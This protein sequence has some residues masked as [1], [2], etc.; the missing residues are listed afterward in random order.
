MKIRVTHFPMPDPRYGQRKF[1][2]ATD[3]RL[4]MCQRVEDLAN[5][6]LDMQVDEWR[7]ISL[8]YKTLPKNTA[9]Q[10]HRRI[11][12]AFNLQG[13]YRFDYIHLRVWRTA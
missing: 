7:R 1:R 3:K 10:D 9:Y 11:K 2:S 8:A 13:V 4:K 12:A 6:M 5:D